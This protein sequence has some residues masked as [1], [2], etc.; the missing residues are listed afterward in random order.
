MKGMFAC[1]VHGCYDAKELG[2]PSVFSDRHLA[3]NVWWATWYMYYPMRLY[4]FRN[5]FTR[6]QIGSKTIT[7]RSNSLHLL[8]C[9][10]IDRRLV[11][12]GK[13]RN[14]IELMFSV[15][16]F[17]NVTLCGVALEIGLL[18]G[19]AGQNSRS[20]FGATHSARICIDTK[21]GFVWG[22]SI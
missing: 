21:F 17:G 10:A 14:L 3:A 12:T 8:P 13:G 11:T 20:P 15:W 19:L 7:M 22:F 4:G 5:A 1:P 2:E 9:M 16:W 18:A 6:E